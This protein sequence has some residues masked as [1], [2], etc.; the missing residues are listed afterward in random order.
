[1]TLL[2]AIL[3]FALDNGGGAYAQMLTQLLPPGRLRTDLSGFLGKLMLAS[4]DELDRVDGRAADLF[5][6]ADPSTANELLPEWES[7]FDVDAA[8]TIEERRANIVSRLIRRQR[9]RP[10]DF[11]QALA[12]LLLQDAEDVV[13]IERS[14]AFCASIGDAREIYRFFVYRDPGLPGTAFIASAQVLVT[15]MKPSHTVGTVIESIALVFDD[16]FSL[17]DR[18]ILGA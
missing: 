13:V 12:P 8:P 7:L 6:E 1:M 2:P 3:A 14:V 16:P 5:N 18:D 10:T 9:F 17:F 11:Q 4:A 15:S